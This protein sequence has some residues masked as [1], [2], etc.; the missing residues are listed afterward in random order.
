[1]AR[2]SSHNGVIWQVHFRS[3]HFLDDLVS[4]LPN[5]SPAKVHGA[6]RGLKEFQALLGE[7][8]DRRIQEFVVMNIAVRKRHLDR[9][10][11]YHNK[12]AKC[13]EIKR[14]DVAVDELGLERR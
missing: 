1:M 2:S 7:H 14:A 6:H 4:S 11:Y 5:A 13:P 3:D 12:F 9:I 10:S 8:P